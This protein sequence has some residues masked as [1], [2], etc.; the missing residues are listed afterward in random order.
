MASPALK[1]VVQVDPPN[2][3]RKTADR[4]MD[5]EIAGFEAFLQEQQRRAGL[6]GNDPLSTPERGIIKAYITY[7]S[8]RK[9]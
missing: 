3:D 5:E 7:A 6:S 1:V 9:S 2:L 4:L 8:T